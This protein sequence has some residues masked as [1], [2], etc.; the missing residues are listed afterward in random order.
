[1][2][3]S[4]KG[5][6]LIYNRPDGQIQLNVRLHDETVWMTQAAIAELFHVKPQNIT[7][8]LKNIYEEGELQETST[9]KDFLQVQQEGSRQ[10]ERRRKF[11][12]LDAIVSIGYRVNSLVATR[13][14][15]WATKTITSY[16]KK[17]FVLDDD[18]LKEPEKDRYFEELLSR[19]RDIRSSEKVFWRKVLDIYST[20]I[21]YDP[22]AEVS[23]LFFQQV[24][25]KMHWATHGQ[26]AAEII[27]DRAD[28]KQPNMGITNYPGN[29]LLKRD[30][31]IAKNYLT[32]EELTVLNRIV[33]A[34]LEMAEIQA[35]NRNPM[36]MRDWAE[37]LDQFLSMT[38][39]K[40]LN[41]AGNLRH[42]VAI[43][44]AHKEYDKY[45]NRMMNKPSDVE[46]HFLEAEQEMKRITDSRTEGDTE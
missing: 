19:I 18:R 17:G 26:T 1:M 15:M 35:L 10:V 33:T 9:C 8:H 38:G 4:T 37:K 30:V 20:S 11:Y 2:D 39:R 24:Q 23:K 21:D 7:M 36:T 13:F 27:F 34:Y 14:R 29:K 22:N 43:E 32:E 5:E 12:N 28:S 42:D 40:L 44:K 6:I 16:L 46:K 31:E 45:R 41:H 25:N 3:Q